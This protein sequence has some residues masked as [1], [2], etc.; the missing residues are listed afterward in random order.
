MLFADCIDFFFIAWVTCGS[1]GK[2][3]RDEHLL[4]K[5]DSEDADD[6]PVITH[7][8]GFLNIDIRANAIGLLL[9]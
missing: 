8:H 5:N 9:L 3:Q 6:K 4:G 1:V 7:H 2:G